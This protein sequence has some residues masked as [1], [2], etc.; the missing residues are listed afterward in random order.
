MNCPHCHSSLTTERE[1]SW[2]P[3]LPLPGLRAAVQRA[4]RDGAEPRSGAARHR[5]PDR[6]LAASLI[7]SRI[8]SAEREPMWRIAVLDDNTPQ[9]QRR[10]PF[11]FHGVSSAWI[12]PARRP[13]TGRT[14]RRPGGSAA[15][16]LTAGG[17]SLDFPGRFAAHRHHGA[18]CLKGDFHQSASSL[19]PC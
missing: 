5:I 8:S 19:N 13:E 15:W 2:F 9:S 11:C 16:Q 6:F 18:R 14:P 7:R 4:N 1:G 10:R 12:T 17:C 3:A